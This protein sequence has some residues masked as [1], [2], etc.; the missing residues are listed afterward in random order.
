[1]NTMPIELRDTVG[2]QIVVLDD[3]T[4]I[5][6]ILYD[7]GWAKRERERKKAFSKKTYVPHG[8][9]GRPRKNPPVQNK[10]DE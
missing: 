7:L 6:D 9:R 5:A 3:G 8:V 1:M 2:G 10:I 4:T